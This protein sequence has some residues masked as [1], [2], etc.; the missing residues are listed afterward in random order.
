M[1]NENKLHIQVLN[2]IDPDFLDEN[3]K[4]NIQDIIEYHIMFSAKDFSEYYKTPDLLVEQVKNILYDS[5]DDK[6]GRIKDLYDTEIKS[7]AKFIV[8]YKDEN[9]FARWA[10]AE[11]ISN[12]I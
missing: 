1:T 10:Y 6:I 9:N 4:P 5:D 11:A 12:V 2:N 3:E 8:D 7:L